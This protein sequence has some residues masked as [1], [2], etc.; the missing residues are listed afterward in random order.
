M[1]CV[2]RVNA[3][4]VY[5]YVLRVCVHVRMHDCKCACVF[6]F[7]L[8]VNLIFH[9]AYQYLSRKEAVDALQMLLKV[10]LLLAVQVLHW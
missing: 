8:A 3:M 4:R 2:L 5:M 7:D 6:G 1:H 10:E 9:I